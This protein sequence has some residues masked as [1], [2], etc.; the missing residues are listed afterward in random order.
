MIKIGELLLLQ[1]HSL[2]I[3][4]EQKA[5]IELKTHEEDKP[6]YVVVNFDETS[7]SSEEKPKTGLTVNGNDE[8]DKAFVTF[9]NW[10]HPFGSA[11]KEPVRFA[12]SDD[13]ADIFLMAS[14]KSSGSVYE[15]TIQFLIEDVAK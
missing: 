11:L 12:L 3:P 14:A 2:L 13:N 1:S 4:K 10:N 6:L 5:T 7:S 9:H 15:L 8:D